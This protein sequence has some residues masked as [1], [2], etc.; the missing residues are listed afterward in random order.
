M[1]K[2]PKV[3]E[4]FLPSVAL[5]GWGVVPPLAASRRLVRAGQALA[6]G[7]PV[8]SSGFRAASVEVVADLEDGS[9]VTKM[10]CVVIHPTLN[11]SRPPSAAA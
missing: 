7:A 4:A 2:P 8:E 10:Q 5:G 9:V 6:V 1:N 3:M 11:S